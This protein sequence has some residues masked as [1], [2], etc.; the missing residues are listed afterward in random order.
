MCGRLQQEIS[1]DCPRDIVGREI[2]VGDFVVQATVWGRSPHM[3]VKQVV[4]VHFY[5]DHWVVSYI[6]GAGGR[7]NGS[8]FSNR[9]KVIDPLEFSEEYIQ[10]FGIDRLALELNK[11]FGESS[12]I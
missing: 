7:K 9:M 8:R 5:E 10:R 2:K 3:S 4:G 11:S 6:D 1:E 12:A